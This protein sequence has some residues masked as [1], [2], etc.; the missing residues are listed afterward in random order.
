[1]THCLEGGGAA[2]IGGGA[3]IFSLF[4]K[5]KASSAPVGVRVCLC[6]QPREGPVGKDCGD[7]VDDATMIECMTTTMT[8]GAGKLSAILTIKRY[9]LC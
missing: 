4:K 5:C 3:E 2:H 9:N 8:R 1:M 6:H 7:V